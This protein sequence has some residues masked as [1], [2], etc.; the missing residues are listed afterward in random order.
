MVITPK[1]DGSPRSVIVFSPLNKNAPRKTHHTKS[2]YV[3][4]SSVPSNKVKTVL[5]NWH[6]YHSIPVHPDDRHLTTFLT[7]YG[8]F[9]YKTT[10]QGFISAGDGYTQRMDI[11]VGDTPDYDHCVDDSIMWDD[12]IE[13]NFYRVCDFLAKCSRSGCIFNPSKFQFAQDEVDFLGFTITK[14]GIRPQEKFLES[15]RSFPSPTS[16]TDVRSWFGLIG[17][18]NYAF[19]STAVMEPFRTLLS[20]KLPFHWSETLE[21]AFQ[22]SKLEIIR[23]CEKGVR[24]FTLDAPTIL[25]TDWSKSAVG[26]WLVQ[27]FCSCQ[28]TLPGCCHTGWQTVHVASKFNSPAVAGYHPIEGEAFAAVWALEKLKIFVLGHPKL[29]LAIDHKPLI[30]ILGPHQ[31]LSDLINPRLMNFKLK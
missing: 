10:P 20:S 11:L 13:E 3:I 21:S 14:T 2:P 9:R 16:I 17:Q 28:A 19:A 8:R 25:A 26:C 6:G 12:S 18:V 27:K 7:P 30:S 31:E 23:Q 29:T 24:S 4:A 22:A 1:H 5:D 15:I